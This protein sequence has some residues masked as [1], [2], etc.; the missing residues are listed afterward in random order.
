MRNIQAV[1]EL[2]R[3][4][5]MC[6]KVIRENIVKLVQ[7]CVTEAHNEPEQ[8]IQLEAPESTVKIET[9]PNASTTVEAEEMYPKSKPNQYTTHTYT[10][11]L[12]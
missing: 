1:V 12:G 10:S 9:K 6:L 2:I 8:N 11:K 5:N 4:K 3:N 7:Y